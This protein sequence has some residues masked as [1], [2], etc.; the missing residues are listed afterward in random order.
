MSDEI[1]PFS[2]EDYRHFLEALDYQREQI[3]ILRSDIAGLNTENQGWLKIYQ[4]HLS[5]IDALEGE[6]LRLR[7]LPE[8]ARE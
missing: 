1:K 2:A 4:R 3:S 6:I 7:S 8:S 5:V